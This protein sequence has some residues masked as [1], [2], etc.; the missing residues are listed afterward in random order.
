[1]DVSIDFKRPATNRAEKV[2]DCLAIHG[3]GMCLP[4]SHTAVIGAKAFVLRTLRVNE[5][6]PA[7]GTDILNG[8]LFL[9]YAYTNIVPA[10]VRLDGVF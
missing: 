5:R 9:F 7:V 2:I 6:A 4:P 8:V 1:M 10:A 3:F